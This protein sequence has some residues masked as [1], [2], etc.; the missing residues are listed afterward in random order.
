MSNDIERFF[1]VKLQSED[2]HNP[3]S[4]FWGGNK[5]GNLNYEPA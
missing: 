1:V 3:P 2:N 4:L 5:K